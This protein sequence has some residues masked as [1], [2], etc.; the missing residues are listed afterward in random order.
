[1]QKLGQARGSEKTSPFQSAPD[2]VLGEVLGTGLARAPVNHQHG[3][4][5][6][7]GAE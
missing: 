1:M 5:H 3:G 6:G 4:L 2:V 7:A